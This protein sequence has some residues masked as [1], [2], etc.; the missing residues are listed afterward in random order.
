MKHILFFLMLTSASYS[1]ELG[2]CPKGAPQICK[3]SP[4]QAINILTNCDLK[5]AKT[6][7]CAQIF[8]NTLSA[9][10]PNAPYYIGFS[11]ITPYP[12][13]SRPK[14][15]RF[16]SKLKKNNPEVVQ[17]LY[18]F[19]Q[20]LILAYSPLNSLKPA[21]ERELENLVGP[22]F[23]AVEDISLAQSTKMEREDFVKKQLSSIAL[24]KWVD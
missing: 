7:Q 8:V 9:V 23:K 2:Y 6:K 18:H 4:A 17:K 24:L 1:T 14:Y 21:E 16:I 19:C 10:D 13:G 5:A 15:G 22:L 12:I 3:L 11:Q 20:A